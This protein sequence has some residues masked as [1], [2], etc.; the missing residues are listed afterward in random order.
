MKL[1]K[2][3]FIILGISFAGELIKE[4]VPLSVPAGIY[5]L[6]ILL[7]LLCAKIVKVEDISMV[8]DWLI[9]AMPLF[10]VPAGVGLMEQWGYLKPMLISVSLIMVVS[11]VF[12]FGAAG[13]VTQALIRK[14]K[15]KPAAEGDG[16]GK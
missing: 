8:S 5:G 7:G 1:V 11:T 3:L 13:T 12:V 2:Q 15:R 10:I 4:L 16:L 9:E 6:L 14:G